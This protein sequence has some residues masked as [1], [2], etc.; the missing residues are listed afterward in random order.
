M[1]M[2]F[3][4]I[5]DT[6]GEIRNFTLKMSIYAPITGTSLVEYF[7]MI[8]NGNRDALC[9]I[10]LIYTII[11]FHSQSSY[12]CRD[13]PHALFFFNISITFIYCL[14]TGFYHTPTFVLFIDTLHAFGSSGYFW[15]SYLM[16]IVRCLEMRF[17]Q[18]SFHLRTL[19]SVGKAFPHEISFVHSVA[20]RGY[21]SPFLL[22]I[23]SPVIC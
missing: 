21:Q 6:Q 9:F 1:E 22:S 17:L 20:I 16:E 4:Q 23:G 14:G 10:L 12:D 13:W 8:I 7:T 5:S 19:V 2:R 3:W 11:F 15:A 18:Q